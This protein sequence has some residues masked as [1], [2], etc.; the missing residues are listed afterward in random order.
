MRARARLLNWARAGVLLLSGAAVAGLVAFAFGR[1]ASTYGVYDLTRD[2]GF[3]DHH[4]PPPDPRSEEEMESLRRFPSGA[5][6]LQPL[7]DATPN[8]GVLHLEPGVYAAP[9][10]VNRPMRVEG[11]RGAIVDGGGVGSI[12]T[13]TANDAQVIGLTLRNSGE[14]H[15]ST[16]SAVR[17]RAARGVYRDNTIENCLFG[18]DLK[19]ADMNI[20]RRNR[21]SSKSLPE[22]LRG[23]SIRIWYSNGNRIED[24]D[25]ERVRD[26]VVWYSRENVIAGN[27]VRDSRYG[28]H[29]MYSHHNRLTNNHF[30]SNT[31]GMFLMY[32]N[33]NTI[34]DNVV[35][36]S[37]GPSGIGIGFKES[38]RVR[39]EHNDVTASARGVYLDASPD[40]PDGPNVFSENRLAYNGVA[41]AFHSTGE[42]SEFGANSFIGN[43]TVATFGGGGS[44]ERNRWKGNY[45]GEY[46]GFDRDRDGVGDTP[47]RV[48]SWADRLWM[49]V[50]DA[51]FFRS[52]PSLELIDLVERLGALT[53]PRLL[54]SDAAPRI[55]PVPQAGARVD[56][57]GLPQ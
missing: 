33:D 26:T 18:F 49:D 50:A 22:A 28:A 57:K 52:A 56:T 51:Q 23:D 4:P 54:L 12:L 24:N 13:V 7:I 45:W 20:I 2:A 37:Q 55:A 42:G 36:N 35:R 21:I 31:V 47:Y 48:W 43:H 5:I 53:E 16:D 11:A 1:L 6:A 46:D 27:R 41:V 32:A 40:D 34:A 44:I 19:Q 38:S 9:G 15:E 10:L 3:A 14:R 8:G 17:L 25:I 30:Q 29:L 39:V